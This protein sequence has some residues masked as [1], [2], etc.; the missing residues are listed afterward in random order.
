[1]A[2]KP[3]FIFSE[4]YI[5]D[6]G[7]HVFPVDKFKKLYEK[8]Q[9]EAKIK[10]ESFIEPTPASKDELLLVHEPEYLDDLVNLRWTPRTSS[11]EVPLNKEIVELSILSA[12][13]TIL[14][15]REALKNNASM[16]LCGGWHHAFPD[17]AEGFCYIHDM[18]IAIKKL[19]NEKLIKKAAVIDCDLHQGN[20]TAY[21]FKND[22]SVFTFSMH[23]ENLYPV[24]Q[25]SNLDIG[26][27]DY[28]EDKE[29]LEKL[30]NALDKIFNEFKPD[31]VMYQAGA[32]SYKDDQLGLLKLTIE[33]FKKRDEMVMERCKKAKVPVAI[34]LGGGYAVKVEDTVQIHYNTAIT[35]LSVF[36]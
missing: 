33:G 34:T 15:C 18:A 29:Y 22:P 28:T 25:K 23:Q 14:T 11:S 30:N 26:L 17:H 27:A 13:G 8:L 31:F 12:G 6:I 35:M 19:Q 1:M 32:D 5:C 20:G 21:I 24:K 3:Y 9:I 10:P 2:V 7:I 36:F 16:H 4:K